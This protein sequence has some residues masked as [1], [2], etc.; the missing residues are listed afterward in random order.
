MPLELRFARLTLTV[1]I[2]VCSRTEA[3]AEAIARDV[4]VDKMGITMGDAPT[5]AS[6]EFTDGACIA[7][8]ET[9]WGEAVPEEASEVGQL[10][11]W[12]ESGAAATYRAP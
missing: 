4:L 8:D 9:V 2:P 6:V 3:E 12:L 11:A 7:D 1:D 10:R 5:V